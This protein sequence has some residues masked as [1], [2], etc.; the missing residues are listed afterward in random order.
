MK[1]Y[2]GKLAPHALNILNYLDDGIYVSDVDGMTIHVNPRYEKLTGLQ[3]DDLLGKNVRDL[4]ASGVLATIVNPEVVEKGAP[5][6]H[7]HPLP[8]GRRIMLKGFPVLDGEGNV[9]L[10][11]TIVRDVTLIGQ[12]RKKLSHQQKVISSY[13]DQIE[14]LTS[15]TLSENILHHSP[16]LQDIT[17]LVE[18]VAAT[19]ATMLFLGES[20]VGKDRF[21]RLAHEHSPRKK[22]SS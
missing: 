22:K 7:V 21:A 19:D 4:K 3:A 2:S 20:G 17:E 13:H 12:M 1:D 16:H 10:V 6:T 15:S 8:D 18:R 9:E 14:T 11:I 5:V